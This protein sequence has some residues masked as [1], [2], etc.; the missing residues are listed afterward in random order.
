[1]L[2]EIAISR[3]PGAGQDCIGL[4]LASLVSCYVQIDARASGLYFAAPDQTDFQKEAA[5]LLAQADDG[6]AT[7]VPF[8]YKIFSSVVCSN[9]RSTKCPAG[10]AA[11]VLSKADDSW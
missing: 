3:I 11:E 8:A 2:S 6:T 10:V 9:W 5:S 7:Y 1:M 4:E